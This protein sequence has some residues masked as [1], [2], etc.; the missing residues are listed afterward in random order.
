MNELRGWYRTYVSEFSH[1]IIP[2]GLKRA[3]II[4]TKDFYNIYQFAYNQLKKD[5]Q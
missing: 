1:A 5:I 3:P 2:G 4:E